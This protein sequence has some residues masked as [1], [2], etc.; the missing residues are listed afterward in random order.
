MHERSEAERRGSTDPVTG[1]DEGRPGGMQSTPE[2]GRPSHTIL[3]FT[4]F[5]LERF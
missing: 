3:F 5:Y 4:S 2:G 1:F